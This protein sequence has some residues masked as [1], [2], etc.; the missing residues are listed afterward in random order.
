MK[1]PLCL[2]AVSFV[3][4]SFLVQIFTFPSPDG[5]AAEKTYPEGDISG[6][7]KGAG[8]RITGQLGKKEIKNNHLIYYLENVRIL[9]TDSESDSDLTSKQNFPKLNQSNKKTGALCYMAGEVSQPIGRW[10]AVEGVLLPF[11]DAENEGQFDA[12]AY[13]GSIGLDLCLWDTKV[14]SEGKRFDRLGE[15]ML[16]IK[17]YVSGRFHHYM[18]RE[19][20]GILQAMLLG[21]KTSMDTEIKELY[22][23]NGIAHILAIS[24][25]HISLIGMFFYRLMRRSYIPPRICAVAGI[26]FVLFYIRLV[27]FSVSSFRAVCMFVLYMLADL[28]E[29]TYDMLSALA[30]SALLTLAEERELL[31]QAGFLLSYLAVLALAVVNPLLQRASEERMRIRREQRKA[32]G[33][34]GERI[35]ANLLSGFSVQV[36]ILPVTLWFYFEVPLYSFLLNLIVIPCMSLVLICGIFGALP[37]GGFLL[38]LV[39]GILK[40]YEWL[41]LAAEGLP[42]ANIVTGRPQIWQVVVYYLLIGAWI[43]YEN[44]KKR[45]KAPKV[46]RFVFPLLCMLI[47]L[48][49]VH[50]E[51]RVDML[52]VGQGD[53]ICLR[54]RL[55]HVALVDGGS[56]DVKNAGT[57]RLL[58]FL[59]YHG[60][61]KVDVIFLSHA[62]ED[63]YSAI[64]ELL[65]EAGNGNIRV[66]TLCLTVAAQEIPEEAYDRLAVLAEKAECEIAFLEAGERVVCGEMKFDC[67]YPEA[68]TDVSDENDRSMVLLARLGEFS[69]LFTGDASE[70]CEEDVILRLSA[71]GINKITCLKVGHHGAGTSTGEELLDAFDFELALI[72][73]GENNS[74]G[75]PHADLLE[76]LEKAGCRTFTTAGCGQITLRL[77]GKET[78]VFF[79]R[80]NSFHMLK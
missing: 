39:D 57:Y 24:G 48:I 59:K 32:T 4:F 51:D 8:I 13:Y 3:V 78:G 69:M 30:F 79:Y 40:C 34:W 1:R 18:S 25:L 74:Y 76:R 47:F 42:F 26:G 27:G 56:T 19:N 53:C 65:E 50:R 2:L 71:L 67:V 75:H 54:D 17:D 58:P 38:Y 14:V 73:C 5:T 9:G 41:C 29:R 60:I 70:A 22:R 68:G 77:R 55:G 35:S 12:A 63:H 23:K 11:A 52:S 80:K 20:A 16:S 45:R 61:E 44:R 64:A 43:A 37:G 21:D 46:P 36:L 49:P 7:N 62:H 15:S 28:L 10:L 72:S 33:G 6:G 31:F 66:G